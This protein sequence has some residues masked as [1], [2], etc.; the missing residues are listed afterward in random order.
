MSLLIPCAL[1]GKREPGKLTHCTWAWY[2][3]DGER[4]A[5]LQKLCFTCVCTS[6]VPLV[7]AAREEPLKCP[8]CHTD[9]GDDMDPVYCTYFLEGVGKQQGEWATCGPCAVAV[10]ERAQRG[11][12]K[13][14]DRPIQSEGQG[15]SPQTDWRELYRSLGLVA[16]DDR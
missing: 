13:R 2:R 10:R 12:T 15:S 8:V 3:A 1:C 4:S 9:P 7:T 16:R 11:A 6:L 14:E 5:W